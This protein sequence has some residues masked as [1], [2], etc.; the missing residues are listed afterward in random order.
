MKQDLSM[1]QDVRR[2]P[3]VACLVRWAM[4][5]AVAGLW[6]MDSAT[7]A[8]DAKP[9]RAAAEGKSDLASIERRA[10][11]V[12]QMAGPAVVRIAYK[13]DREEPLYS[14]VIVSADGHVLT[15]GVYR[16]EFHQGA[17]LVV[18][19]SD[20]RRVPGTALGWSGEWNLGL[21]KMAQK[22]PWPCA[23]FRE[24][25]DVMAGELCLALGYLPRGGRA[26]FDGQ[27]ALRLGCVTRCAYPLWLGSSCLPGFHG[28]GL[29]DLDGRLIG[30][31]TALWTGQDYA[32]CTSAEVAKTHWEDLV[33]GT[34]LDRARLFPA[35]E[36]RPAA[37]ATKPSKSEPEGSEK[38]VSAA[39]EKAKAATVRIVA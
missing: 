33:A 37:Q 12:Y 11:A 7:G 10:Q 26:D 34:N 36:V 21:I 20:G 31:T 19:L 2:Q 17:P 32:V 23:R 9:P 5:I 38:R 39:I 25:A 35:D 14:G 16:R 24:K 6:L 29:F 30:V 8:Q 3:H 27:P 18:V 15:M 1:V 22:G 4:A 13:K 28:E